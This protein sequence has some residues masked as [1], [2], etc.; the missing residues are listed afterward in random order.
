[1]SAA[2]AIVYAVGVIAAV[3]GIGVVL[4]QHTLYSALS[5]VCNMVSL[6]VLFLLL[7]AQFLAA[8]QVIIYA[9]A[10]MVLFVF[11]IALLNPGSATER[12]RPV[13]TDAYAALGAVAVV[14]MTVMVFALAL[15]GT[16]Y[17]RSTGQLHGQALAMASQPDDRISFQYDVDSVNRN[18][19]VQ[20]VGETLFTRFL[21]PF[22]ITSALLLVAAIGAVYLTRRA[23]TDR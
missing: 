22:E 7:N 14:G 1:M 2:T 20:T 4:A 21:L 11:I 12:E 19:N 3:S 17:D 23:R 6:A 5:L 18:G 16:T 15:N 8:V 9:G 10:V 13:W